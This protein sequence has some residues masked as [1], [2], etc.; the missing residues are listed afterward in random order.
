[1]WLLGK[2]V[3]YRIQ[4]GNQSSQRLYRLHNPSQVE[5]PPG[6][7]P[8]LHRKIPGGPGI[9]MLLTTEEFTKPKGCN[10]G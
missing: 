6:H 8:A 5:A 1:M 9:E 4:N 7:S 2:I 3:A 10:T